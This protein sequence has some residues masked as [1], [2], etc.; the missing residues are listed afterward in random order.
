MKSQPKKKLC[1]EEVTILR[2]LLTPKILVVK[3]Q[4]HAL[5]AALQGCTKLGS[6]TSL[7]TKQCND[8][9]VEIAA[10]ASHKIK[11]N[12]YHKKLLNSQ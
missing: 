12:N 9:S 10:I 4:I 11:H 2:G 3:T 7:E 1:R 8:G 5:N 6:V